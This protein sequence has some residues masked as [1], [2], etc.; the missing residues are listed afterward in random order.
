MPE[1]PDI[2]VYLEALHDRT[3]G[4]RLEHSRIVSPFLL[5]SFEPRLE[6]A[7]GQR[8]VA[9]ARVGKRIVIGFETDLWLIIHLMIAGRLHWRASAPQRVTKQTA[10]V[11][12][13]EQ[14]ALL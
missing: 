4:H 13:F 11:L 2:T 12:V 1:L 10:L 3:H 14:G 6:E 5:R 9:L 7:H 8:V